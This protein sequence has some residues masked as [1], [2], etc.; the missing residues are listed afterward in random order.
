MEFIKNNWFVLL[1]GV[2]GFAEIVVRL[3]PTEKD[4]SILEWVKKLIGVFVPNKK[5]GGGV[6]RS[7]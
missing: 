3:T 6:F 4:N 7:K 1:M 5:S 2:I